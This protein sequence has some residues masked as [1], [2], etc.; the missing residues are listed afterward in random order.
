[1]SNWYEL[2]E[3]LV[4]ILLKKLDKVC[5]YIR[6]CGV[7]LSWRSIGKSD[8]HRIRHQLPC[9]LFFN[10]KFLPFTNL[11]LDAPP[12]LP[13]LSMPRS[14]CR[15]SYKGWLFMVN[16]DYTMHLQ[17]P[18]SGQQ[19]P[20]PSAGRYLDEYHP[21]QIIQI[22][23]DECYRCYIEKGHYMGY[24]ITDFQVYKQDYITKQWRE[25]K[26]IGEYALF[27]GY[28]QSFA[29]SATDYSEEIQANSIYF[30]DDKKQVDG[31]HEHKLWELE[32]SIGRG[33]G[34]YDIGQDEIITSFRSTTSNAAAGPSIWWVV[35][36]T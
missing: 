2:P 21:C 36:K 26:D 34:I 8:S 4:L 13:T 15:C 20:L 28:N 7:C 31:F 5:D 30:T 1:M 19:I 14:L 3:D 11:H 33:M 29:L 32:W 18:I 23:C 35:P 16:Q 27:L 12:K 9:L 10:G 25:V 22:D 6:F 17:N 24:K